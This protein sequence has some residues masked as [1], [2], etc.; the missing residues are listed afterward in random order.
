MPNENRSHGTTLVAECGLNPTTAPPNTTTTKTKKKDERIKE[1]EEYFITKETL[2][3][4]SI[5]GVG[6]NPQLAH[7]ISKSNKRNEYNF[8]T[9]Y[10]EANAAARIEFFASGLRSAGT[11]WFS[12]R[13][14]P[15]SSTVPSLHIMVLSSCIWTSDTNVLGSFN[16]ERQYYNS[17]R[18]GCMDIIKCPYGPYAVHTFNLQAVQ[19][20]SIGYHSW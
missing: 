20:I 14:F 3:T 18:S 13:K 7:E 10:V 11:V 2:L 12:T 9:N 4:T 19:P 15:K 16:D 8:E 17:P 6:G 5:A 1:K